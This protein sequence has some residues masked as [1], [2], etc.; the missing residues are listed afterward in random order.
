MDVVNNRLNEKQRDFFRKFCNYTGEQIYF[1]GSIQRMDYIKGKSDIDIDIFTNNLPSLIH[2]ISMFLNIEKH[3]FRKT[4]FKLGNNV[5][6]G[7]KTMYINEEN[8]IKVEISLYDE[9]YKS[10]VLADHKRGC[11]LPL[12]ITIALY[13]VK[14]L[15]YEFGIISIDV[16]R[17]I[18][19]ILINSDELRFIVLDNII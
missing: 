19:N 14:V 2:K 16:Y 3:N 6:Y 5:I 13:I 9:K 10:L 1:Y 7:S 8:D 15:Y 11:N 17:R 4:I 18:K 12:Y